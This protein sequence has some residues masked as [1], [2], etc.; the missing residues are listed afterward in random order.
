MNLPITEW[1]S[2]MDSASADISRLSQSLVN[3]DHELTER[4]R[5]VCINWRLR[6][7]SAREQQSLN[8]LAA[9]VLPVLEA[10][11][12]VL[13]EKNTKNFSFAAE[14]IENRLPDIEAS[15]LEVRHFAQDLL[16]WVHKY[17]TEVND[18]LVEEYRSAYGQLISM[19]PRIKPRLQQ[20]HEDLVG[21]SGDEGL[22]DKGLGDRGLCDAARRLHSALTR[23]L[24]VLEAAHAFVG[25]VVKPPLELVF[26]ET[27]SFLEDLQAI[28][29]P[30]RRELA[31]NLNDICQS[32]LY[33]PQRFESAVEHMT[34]DCEPGM[35]S[36]LVVFRHAGFTLYL[37]VEEDPIFGH[38]TVQ[39]LRAV[40]HEHAESA[41]LW[42]ATSLNREW[43]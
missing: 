12:A 18:R 16:H 28:E 40:G 15:F 31:S 22:G 35:D 43:G 37:T 20:L 24:A 17:N 14:Q 13:R 9:C 2:M 3:P 23:Y 4:A 7:R 41:G 39:L 19:A 6:E 32:L 8:I 30:L 26:E 29:L 5:Q 42:V 27:E 1:Q 38:M 34:L 36:S 25:A 33:D 10:I 21:L 11:D